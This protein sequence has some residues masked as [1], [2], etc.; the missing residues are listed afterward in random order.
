MVLSVISKSINQSLHGR[1]HMHNVLNGGSDLW[2]IAITALVSMGGLCIMVSDFLKDIGASFVKN[3]H[4][5]F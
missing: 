5:E 2:L 3:E 1:N 4:R